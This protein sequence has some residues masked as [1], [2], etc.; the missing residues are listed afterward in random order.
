MNAS[1]A[2]SLFTWSTR[3]RTRLYLVLSN[4]RVSSQILDRFITNMD[5]NRHYFMAAD[6]EEF[7]TYRYE[8]DDAVKRGDLDLV[9]EIY[10][11]YVQRT[12]ER[13]E[14]S[15]SLLDVEPDFAVDE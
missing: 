10:S 14:Y 11:R 13:L 3:F 4:S 15:V 12:R 1:N 8:F 2:S 7:E 6:I 5:G 9:F